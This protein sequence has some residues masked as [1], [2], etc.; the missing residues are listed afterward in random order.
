MKKI[1]GLCL[2]FFLLSSS[3][4]CQIFQDDLSWDKSIPIFFEEDFTQ[5]L[6][7]WSMHYSWGPLL[8]IGHFTLSD[9]DNIILDTQNGGW[10]NLKLDKYDPPRLYNG[11]DFYFR[12]STVYSNQT[13]QYGYFEASL[14]VTKARGIWPAFWLY[15]SYD[16]PP[17]CFYNEIDIFEPHGEDCKTNTTYG[18]NVLWWTACNVDP[19]FKVQ[20]YNVSDMTLEHKYAIEWSPNL[21]IWYQDDKIVRYLIDPNNVIHHPLHIMFDMKLSV[22]GTYH[23]ENVADLV[24]PSYL[25]VNYIKVYKLKSDGVCSDNI[26]LCN[27]DKNTFNFK[28]YQNINIGE[29]LCSN[30]FHTEDNIFFRATESIVLNANTEIN[31]LN[32]TGGFTAIII[33]CPPSN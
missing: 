22:D 9:I 29:N 11:T 21:I 25:D 2:G 6:S 28:V 16:P 4:Y 3:L 33:G 23:Y 26:T 14:K 15:N 24:I 27:F 31:T 30:T 1:L 17:G 10:L 18:T 12:G 32:N 13:I 8:H 20:I 5:D 19:T 7:N